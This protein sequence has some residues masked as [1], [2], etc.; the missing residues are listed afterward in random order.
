MKI[1]RFV[2]LIMMP[3]FAVALPPAGFAAEE[4][5]LLVAQK[6]KTKKSAKS[7]KKGYDYEKSKYK[8]YRVLTDKET[9]SYKFDEK[10]NPI[11]PASKKK[12]ARKKVQ[13]KP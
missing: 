11:P 3:V 13:P 7:K 1:I 10:G 6:P 4:A 2:S 8:A 9:R 12:P 5:V